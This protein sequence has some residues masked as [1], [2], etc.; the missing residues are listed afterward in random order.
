M[1]KV[2][3]IS[4][5]PLFTGAE[6]MLFH[7]ALMLSKTKEYLPVVFIPD[8]NES[9]SLKKACEKY[10]IEVA[11]YPASS[12]YIWSD[13]E[14]LDSICENT[15]E[16]QGV[17]E[18]LYRQ[19]G[20]DL[21]VVNT[22]TQ[23]APVLA[24]RKVNLPTCLWIHGILDSYLIPQGDMTLRL[25]IDRYLINL[26]D[27]VVCCSE[28]TANYY[29]PIASK[30]VSIITNWIEPPEKTEPISAKNA[31]V[32]LNT[33]DENKGVGTLLEAAE[34]LAEKGYHFSLRLYGAGGE[35]SKLRAFVQKKKLD[36]VVQFCGRT[37]HVDAVYRSCSCLV[38]PSYIE[39]FGLT[40]VE[41][42]A[43]GRPV[44]SA[45][46]GGGEMIVKHGETGYLV[47]KKDAKELAE[48]MAE[49]MDTPGLAQNMGMAGRKRYEELFSPEKARHE[50]LTL[51][52]SML[53][54]QD[55]P[56][57]ADILLW[58]TWEWI[59]SHYKAGTH[60]AEEP[61]P[62]AVQIPDIKRSAGR[63]RRILSYL[64]KSDIHDMIRSMN[65]T[66]YDQACAQMGVTQRR[67]FKESAVI[68]WDGYIEYVVRGTG[69]KIQYV[70]IGNENDS[71][72]IEA[73]CKKRI[74]MSK[75]VPVKS[76][77]IVSCD[78]GAVDGKV[79]IRFRAL[80]PDAKIHTVE[81]LELLKVRKPLSLFGWIS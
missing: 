14:N 32:C 44:I 36:S 16:K 78:L 28:W 23:I 53:R 69:T 5:S 56:S 42:M 4:H 47:R 24:A 22:L 80:G 52:D 26:S 77:R 73:V 46:N 64:K 61:K 31:F 58:D 63:I 12:W 35:E 7:M 60:P 34:I 57:Q 49:M 37:N 25:L 18:S 21:V 68:P 3:L 59:F 75:T 66:M 55:E 39:S 6:K 54:K 33:F 30:Q 62:P 72:M 76:G 20:I 65:P 19:Y 10:A 50:F 13:A 71:C 2:A 17:L 45:K 1:I 81:R 74:I 48:R 51:F 29:Q 40:M 15:W 41:A 67:S 11:Y 70:L 9:D 8:N 38:Q 79:A 43:N 27:Q